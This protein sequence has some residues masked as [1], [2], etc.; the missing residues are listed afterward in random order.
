MPGDL[1]LLYTNEVVTGRGDLVEG[2]SSLRS[3]SVALR[4]QPSDGWAQ[5]AL[6][7]VQPGS[8]HQV[9]LAALRIVD[10]GPVPA[11]AG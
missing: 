2:L 1:L 8:P 9:T 3:A 6:A 4:H 11:L 10:A 7:A 5:R